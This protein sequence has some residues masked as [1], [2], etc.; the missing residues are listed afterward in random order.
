ML[1]VMNGGIPPRLNGIKIEIK[2]KYNSLKIGIKSFYLHGQ[3]R[4][5]LKSLIS[6][7]LFI[8]ALELC[9]LRK[10][11][12]HFGLIDTTNLIEIPGLYNLLILSFERLLRIFLVIPSRLIIAFINSKDIN[13]LKFPKPDVNVNLG[14]H[15]YVGTLNI[16]I[17]SFK[18]NNNS[19]N[20]VDKCNPEQSLLQININN[21]N[22]KNHL[23]SIIEISI[24][25]LMKEKKIGL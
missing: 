5:I 9:F 20:F 14:I 15:D 17:N 19:N 3:L 11:I 16:S 12:I 4:F 1:V 23:I 10:S 21:S 24:K 25:T 18:N 2:M 7:I 22:N 13:Q 8:S 6:K